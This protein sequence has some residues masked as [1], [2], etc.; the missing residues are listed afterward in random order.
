M[1][2]NAITLEI[3][4]ALINNNISWQQAL[5]QLKPITHGAKSWTTKKWKEERN[6]IIEDHCT[7]CGSSKPPMVL[8]HFSHPDK[9]GKIFR[10]FCG[11][12][13]WP[14]FKKKYDY[15]LGKDLLIDRPTCPNCESTNIHE[16]KTG[17]WSCYKCHTK[18]NVPIIKPSF[19]QEGIKKL[20][21]RH[22]DP[23]QA[24]NRW[25]VFQQYYGMV[26]GKKAVLEFINQSRYYLS[27]G[28]TATF[29]K[30]CAYS[31]D[32]TGI[33]LCSSCKKNWHPHY[34]NEC[35]HCAQQSRQ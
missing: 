26:V 25:R 27:F 24:D 1:E 19:T 35:K 34:M 11:P 12:N 5:V 14:A 7:Q 32:V 33:R 20:T 15:V 13:A 6:E 10:S 9:F 30:S 21:K 4:K 8:Q 28:D 31:W 2:I 17:K 23:V 3:E 29:C 22:H 16:L 18:H